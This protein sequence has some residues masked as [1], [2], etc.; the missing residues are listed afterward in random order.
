MRE[1]R[2][3]VH[4]MFALFLG[5]KNWEGIALQIVFTG[6]HLAGPVHRVPLVVGNT[7]FLFAHKGVFSVTIYGTFIPFGKTGVG[8][9]SAKQ[10]R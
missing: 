1:S 7:K 8:G 4:E 5:A 9:C 2:R 6:H 3:S 10:G